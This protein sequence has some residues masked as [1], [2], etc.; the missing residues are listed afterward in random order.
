MYDQRKP[1][2]EE[3]LSEFNEQHPTI[4]F[5]MEK[6]SHKFINFL[7]LSVHRKEKDLEFEI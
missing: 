5:A 1:N 7:D 3:T 4:K 6:K 2:I